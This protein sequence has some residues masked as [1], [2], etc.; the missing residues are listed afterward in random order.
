ML[1]VALMSLLV[2]SGAFAVS[3]ERTDSGSDLAYLRA[4]Q[5][6]FRDVADQIRPALV[7]IE[8]VGGS[9]PAR[10]MPLDPEEETGEGDPEIPDEDPPDPS[11]FRDTTGSSFVVADGPTTGLVYS[12]DGYIITSSFNFIRD[13]LLVTVALADGRRLEATVVARDQ[14]RKIALLKVDAEDLPEPTWRDADEVAVGERV[15]ALG[16]GF[17]GDHPSVTT[18][19]ISAK[20]RMLGNAVQTDAKLS[21]A[22]YGGPVCDVFGRVVGLAVPMAQR[23]G[24]LAGIELYDSGIGFAVTR[25]RVEEIVDTLKTGQSLYRGWLGVS[26]NMA[27]RDGVEITQVA[28][29]SPLAAAGVRTGDR[30]VWA[31]GKELHHPDKLIQA[32][33]MIPA[34]ELVRIIIERNEI[35]FALEVRLARNT[36]LGDL[37]DRNPVVDPRAFLERDPFKPR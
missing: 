24:E 35:P 30:I 9:Q 34:G 4:T 6:V 19:I 12:R 11:P 27:S 25:D 28:H 16:L 8:T 3:P 5:Q 13:P 29:R 23:P 18:G 26:M 20:A 10:V 17:G 32:L 15:V 33:Y 31:E 2:V 1:L 14:V 37:M 7:R 21:P 22:N 36:E